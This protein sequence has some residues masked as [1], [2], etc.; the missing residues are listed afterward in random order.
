MLNTKL[1][2][3]CHTFETF[4]ERI[5]LHPKSKNVLPVILGFPH[6]IAVVSAT[7]ASEKGKGFL[8]PE[9]PLHS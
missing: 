5:N 1:P 8:T 3:L 4:V 7:A 6:G 9:E 2:Q